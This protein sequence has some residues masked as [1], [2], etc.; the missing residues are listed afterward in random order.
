M[1]DNCY[2]DFLK[3]LGLYV[4]D[5]LSAN[6]LIT[7]LEDMMGGQD[8]RDVFDELKVFL[9]IRGGPATK[10]RFNVPM[11][12]IDFTNCPSSGVSYR[13]VP[14]DYPLPSCTGRTE[15][16]EQ[17]LNDEW[18]S[19]PSGSEDFN[20]THYRKNQYE[21]SLFKCEDDRFELD[22][23]IE[24]NASTMRIMQSML[25]DADKD[26][27]RNSKLNLGV[28]KAVHLKAIE[29]VYGDHG[30]EMVDHLKRA[31]R[32]ALNVVLPR[33]KHKDE[34]GVVTCAEPFRIWDSFSQYCCSTWLIARE[35]SWIFV[36]QMCCLK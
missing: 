21:E 16:C 13:S 18:V 24:T 14:R 22:M 1:G 29:R 20:Y 7:V 31:P 6:E 8:V 36:C 23:L 33:L 10:Y 12:E 34:V 9:G 11:S 26:R 35:R 25:E 19:V 17:T 5:V 15:L 4:Q 32:I 3:C 2:N 27:N 28:L 30:A